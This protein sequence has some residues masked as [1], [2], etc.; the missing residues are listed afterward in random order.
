MRFARN[1]DGASAIEFAIIAPLFITM[2][3]GILGYGSYFGAVHSVQQL[4][5]SAARASI[6][7]LTSS[8]RKSLALKYV[9]G[10]SS[11]Y[12]LLKASKIV[13]DAG[14]SGDDPDAFKV[15]ISYDGRSLPI[16]VFASLI[17]V[18]QKTIRSVSV[19]KRGGY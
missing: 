12:P 6:G 14:V 13:T 16:F 1:D 9:A 18:P 17:P 10:A 15:T 5:A 8:E 4:S 7:G 3:V 2:I 19:I 11:N